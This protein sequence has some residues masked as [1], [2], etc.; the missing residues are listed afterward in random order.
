MRWIALA[1]VVLVGCNRAREDDCA[2]VKKTLESGGGFAA[3][4]A[5]AFEDDEVAAAV[6]AMIDE[7]AWTSYQPYQETK[8]PSNSGADLLAR[9]CK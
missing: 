9:V 1:L 6:K 2:R 8:A 3:L 7:T 4:R 5:M